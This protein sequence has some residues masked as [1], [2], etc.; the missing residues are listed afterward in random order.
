MMLGLACGVKIYA[1]LIGVGL[2]YPLLRRREWLRVTLMTVVAVAMLGIGYSF[3]G[4]DALKPVFGGLQLVTLPS[5]WRIVELIG[6]SAEP[7]LNVLN[8]GSRHVR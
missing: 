5:P 1:V 4:L 2:A 3:Y 7:C 6:S 8:P